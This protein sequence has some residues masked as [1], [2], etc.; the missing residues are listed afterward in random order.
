MET[1]KNGLLHF[2]SFFLYNFDDIAFNVS[3][4]NLEARILVLSEP[5]SM[6][7]LYRIEFRYGR[8]KLMNDIPLSVLLAFPVTLQRFV[9]FLS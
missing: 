2:I 1:V 9:S 4:W 3:A 8:T 5:C 6:N 7:P